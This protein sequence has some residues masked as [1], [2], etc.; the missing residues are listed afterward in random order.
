MNNSQQPENSESSFFEDFSYKYLPFWPLLIFFLIVFGVSAWVYL[1][2]TT[3]VYGVS[4]TILIND[5]KKGADENKIEES[6]N[7]LSSNK[8][9]ENEIEVIRS[10]KLMEEVVKALHLYAPVYEEGK[11]KVNSAYLSSPVSIEVGEPEKL[12]PFFNIYFT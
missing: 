12:K 7:L 2:Y 1:R 9:V 4:S 10:R 6:L 8:I 11:V 3:P 5:E